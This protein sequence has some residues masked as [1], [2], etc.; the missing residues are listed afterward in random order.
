M[1]TEVGL[2]LQVGMSLTPVIEVV[3]AHV[4]LTVP[5]NPYVPT[6]LMGTVLPVVA[7]G[8]TDSV[9]VPVPELG[10]KLGSLVIVSA[11][12]VFSISVPDVPVMVT[13]AGVESTAAEELAV[14]V[15]TSVSAAVP[16]AKLDVTP[17]GRPDA[18]NATVPVNP[19][20]GVMVTV[21]VPDSP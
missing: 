3:T 9:A 4:R 17:E 8:L 12:V 10:P 13:V 18:V 5:E 7:P 20:A 1:L 16:A 14:R 2:R 11:T 21:L 15:S 6:T 19:F